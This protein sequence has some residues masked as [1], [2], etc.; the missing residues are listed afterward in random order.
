MM[1]N[2]IDDK[3]SWPHKGQPQNADKKLDILVDKISSEIGSPRNL[4]KNTLHQA[5]QKGDLICRES[6]DRIRWQWSDYLE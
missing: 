5:L 3:G 6:N 4:I 2:V 1:K